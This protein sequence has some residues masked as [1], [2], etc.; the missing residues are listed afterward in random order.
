MLF[1]PTVISSSLK[2][3]LE[4]TSP[5]FFFFSRLGLYSPYFKALMFEISLISLIRTPTWMII[6]KLN[7]IGL[8]YFLPCFSED[9]GGLMDKCIINPHK[10]WQADIF[11]NCLAG[12]QI[13]DVLCPDNPAQYPDR[14]RGTHHIWAP[15]AG[16]WLC[17]AANS[18][19]EMQN[20]VLKQRQGALWVHK[21]RF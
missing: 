2:I 9:S 14:G 21:D 16:T 20:T 10:I 12:I 11:K 17:L 4:C 13:A 15:A 5:F 1:I 8:F 7:Q 6:L 18:T 3:L 19:T